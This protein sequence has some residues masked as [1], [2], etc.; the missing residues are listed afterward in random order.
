MSLQLTCLDSLTPRASASL[1]RLCLSPSTVSWWDPVSRWLLTQPRERASDLEP[2]LQRLLPPCLEFLAP[3]LLRRETRSTE[4]STSSL[5]GGTQ[6][7]LFPQDLRLHP[8]H[9]V[10][11]CC[12][13][14]EVCTTVLESHAYDCYTDYKLT[15]RLMSYVRSSYVIF[16]ENFS[17]YGM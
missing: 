14:L 1:P 9:L 12:T 15:L 16:E 7:R 8:V 13:I 4:V 3:V 6:L 11:T 2:H 5:S 17:L 10:T